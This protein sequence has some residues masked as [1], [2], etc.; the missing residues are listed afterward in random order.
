MTFDGA[1]SKIVGGP[2]H[3]GKIRRTMAKFELIT[4]FSEVENRRA[5][6][7]RPTPPADSKNRTMTVGIRSPFLMLRFAVRPP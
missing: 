6:V 1:N 7:G 4:T 5:I 3:N 2:D